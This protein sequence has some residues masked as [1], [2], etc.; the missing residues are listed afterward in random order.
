MNFFPLIITLVAGLS[1]AIGAL[2]V[3]AKRNKFTESFALAFATGIMLMISLGE[4]VPDSVENLGLAGSLVLFSVGAF[5][6]MF[7]DLVLPHHH[8]HDKEEPI[9]KKPG[10]YIDECECTHSESVSKGMITALVLHNILEGLAT[11]LTAF[12]DYRLGLSMAI[13]I[14]IHNIPIGATLGISLQSSGLSKSKSIIKTVFVG[15]S[16]PLGALIGLLFFNFTGNTIIL[17][18]CMAIVAGVLIFIAFDELWPAARLSG[19]RNMII[20]ALVLGICFIPITE[21]LI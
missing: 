18:S 4:L 7:L 11:G 15:L 17:A 14:A 6:S 12:N 13:G 10:H 1:T 19:S 3:T 5:L 9:L 2:F 20:I 16:Q 21:A 8:D